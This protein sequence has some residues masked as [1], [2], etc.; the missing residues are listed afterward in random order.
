MSAAKGLL[1]AGGPDAKF[2]TPGWFLQF[3]LPTT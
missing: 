3:Y 1:K 2:T